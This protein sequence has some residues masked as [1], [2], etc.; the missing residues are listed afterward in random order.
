MEDIAAGYDQGKTCIRVF[1]E[2]FAIGIMTF[3]QD[4]ATRRT[5][6]F[7]WILVGVFW[8]LLS[9]AITGQFYFNGIGTWEMVLGMTARDFLPWVILTPLVVWLAERFPLEQERW[10]LSLPVHILACIATVGGCAVIGGMFF[11]PPAMQP[12]GFPT[13]PPPSHFPKGFMPPP[14]PPNADGARP[15]RF[16]IASIMVR[17][18]APVYW[19]IVSL[20]HGLR[21]YRRSQE[22]ERKAADLAARLAEARLQTLK[23]QLQ[24][25]FLFNALNAIATLV[26]KDPD[27][28]DEM[29][30]NLSELLRL[31]LDPSQQQEVPLRQELEFL[32]HYLQIEQARFGD[33]L[34]VDVDVEPR[35][36]EALVPPL[37]LQPLVENAV[38]HGIE[39]QLKPGVI[40]I[41]AFAEGPMLCLSV[42]DNGAGIRSSSPPGHGI[43][44]SNTRARLQA[45][46][47]SDGCL[48]LPENGVDGW[49]AE[50]RLPLHYAQHAT[51]SSKA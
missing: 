42:R 8:V 48:L 10:R 3:M 44:L 38:R 41:R 25:H 34:S 11:K 13:N 6:V 14:G 39:P 5:Q 36:N 33:R 9:M 50:I 32:Q 51:V 16:G 37:I 17:F 45:L 46:Y 30:G 47:G 43:G 1:R 31:T 7:V 2:V 12:T 15:F 24:P 20:A 18:N 49:E 28:A 23:M 35:L 40:T 4:D 22:R 21:F 29:I 27:A 26:H 19:A